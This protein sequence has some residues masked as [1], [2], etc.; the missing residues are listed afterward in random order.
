[1]KWLPWHRSLFLWGGVNTEFSLWPKQ[2]ERSLIP[3]HFKQNTESFCAGDADWV[4]LRQVDETKYET[5]VSG[6][7]RGCGWR[8]VFNRL[9]EYGKEWTEHSLCGCWQIWSDISKWIHLTRPRG[10]DSCCIMNFTV[11]SFLQSK[12]KSEMNQRHHWWL[13]TFGCP[14]LA[15]GSWGSTAA[16]VCRVTTYL[17]IKIPWTTRFPVFIFTSHRRLAIS[18]FTGPHCSGLKPWCWYHTAAQWGGFWHHLSLRIISEGFISLYEHPK[19]N[20]S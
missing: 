9:F 2:F 20:I 10:C 19:M 18:L 6:S 4:G 11:L 1:M 8:I 16:S 5:K 12:N 17:C 7:S 15:Q 3:K 13:E 14:F